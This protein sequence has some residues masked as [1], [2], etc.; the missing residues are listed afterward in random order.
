MIKYCL[1]RRFIGYFLE[2]YQTV[3]WV[4]LKLNAYAGFHKELS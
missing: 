4:F 3:V 1:K 2:P